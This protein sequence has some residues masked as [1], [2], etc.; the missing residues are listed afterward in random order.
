MIL[1][2]DIHDNIHN[3]P[4][5]LEY[6]IEGHNKDSLSNSSKDVE[7]KNVANIAD[8]GNNKDN[9]VLYKKGTKGQHTENDSIEF[10]TLNCK[11]I[12]E[13]DLDKKENSNEMPN[14]KNIYPTNTVYATSDFEIKRNSKKET[15]NLLNMVETNSP[16]AMV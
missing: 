3:I 4:L 16:V 10:L 14:D 13:V 7:N 8:K 5:V 9:F 1:Q 2:K 15:G 6:T 11:N 12:E